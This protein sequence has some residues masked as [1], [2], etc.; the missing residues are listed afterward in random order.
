MTRRYPS[1]CAVGAIVTRRSERERRGHVANPG[2]RQDAVPPG[3]GPGPGGT[4]F[5]GSEGAS[6]TSAILAAV[7][8]LDESRLDRAR[9]HVRVMR[10]LHV[11]RWQERRAARQSASPGPRTPRV[12]RARCAEARQAGQGRR[13][14]AETSSVGRSERTEWVELRSTWAAGERAQASAR[15][16]RSAGAPSAA[17]PRAAPRPAMSAP[18]ESPQGSELAL[19]PAAAGGSWCAPPP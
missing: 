8:A 14:R 15:F 4:S 11:D 12:T 2:V 6:G 7:G 9:L 10:L 17:P 16:W 3:R 5:I 1:N 13:A 18:R 19:P